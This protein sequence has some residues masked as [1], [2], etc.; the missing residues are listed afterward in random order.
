MRRLLKVHPNRYKSVKSDPAS[1]P[2]TA[3]FQLSGGLKPGCLAMLRAFPDRF[4]IGS[5]RFYDTPSPRT[6]RARRFVDLLPANLAPL[7]AYQN[8]QRVYR[9]PAGGH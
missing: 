9:L 6:E 3:P 4:V 2:Q 1:S 8:V 5:D 7:V